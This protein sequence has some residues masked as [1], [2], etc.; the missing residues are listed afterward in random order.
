MKIKKFTEALETGCQTP[1]AVYNI[2]ISENEITLNVK[3]PFDLNLTE[4]EAE[5]LESNL[6]NITEIVLSKYFYKN[7]TS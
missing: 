5:L 7:G 3:L 2:N 6:H 1:E 4:Q